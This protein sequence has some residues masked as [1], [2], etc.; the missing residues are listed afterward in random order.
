MSPVHALQPRA[1]S[2][3]L[4]AA[5][6]AVLLSALG[7]QY[8]G[9]LPPCHLCIL[10]RYPY[11]A[12]IVVGI[13]GSFWQPRL[14]LGLAAAVLLASAG[15]AG[16]HLGVEQGWWALPAGCVAGGNAGSV[17]EL[18]R[19]LA[20]APPTCD[21]VSF[22]FLGLSLAAWN[23]LISLA[24]AAFAVAFALAGGRQPHETAS[25]AG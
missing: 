5:A 14:M 19:M 23:G 11:A 2:L 20:E 22:T 21:R 25:Q 18:R 15:L 10:Q 9:G 24:L 6:V 7:L 4:A 12:L 3:L 1:A 16:Y 17:E 8:L 13:I